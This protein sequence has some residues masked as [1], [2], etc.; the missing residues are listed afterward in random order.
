MILRTVRYISMLILRYIAAM[1]QAG[2]VK[3]SSYVDLPSINKM[4]QYFTLE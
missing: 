3:F 4:F 2:K 1:D